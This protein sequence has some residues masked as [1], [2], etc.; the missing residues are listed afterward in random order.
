MVRHT[1]IACAGVAALGFAALA[2][3]AGWRA[4]LGLSIGV[5]LGAVNITLI[6]RATSRSGAVRVTS[7]GRLGVL[8]AVGLGLGLLIAPLAAVLVVVGLAAA[9]LLVSV[10]AAVEAVHAS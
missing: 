3:T 2:L 6:E 9:M 10:V 8:S 1:V 5:A 4:G 7:L